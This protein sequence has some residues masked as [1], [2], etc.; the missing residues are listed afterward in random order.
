MGKT[1][2][3]WKKELS[4]EQFKVLRQGGTEAPFSGDFIKPGQQKGIYKC[5]ACG[6]ELFSTDTQ[7]EST[8]PGLQG[9]PSFGD[10]LDAG[11]VELKEDYDLGMK[12]TEV[13]CKTC[14]GHLGHL[15]DDPSAKEHGGKHYCINSV[16]LAF[17]PQE[18]KELEKS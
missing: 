7:Y 13:V 11:K 18:Y 3:E 4:P 6:A 12:R 5:V 17:E 8:M 1:D 9:W 16:C 15:F 14:G 2:D 10:V